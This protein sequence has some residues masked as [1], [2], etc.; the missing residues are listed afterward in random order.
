MRKEGKFPPG[1]VALATDHLYGGAFGLGRAMTTVITA[2]ILVACAC[3]YIAF[4][5]ASYIAAM[6]PPD[7]TER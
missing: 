4:R 7:G 6:G 5:R 1:R 3:Y 2:A